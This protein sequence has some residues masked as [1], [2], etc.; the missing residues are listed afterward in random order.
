MDCPQS[1]ECEF[2]WCED[3]KD[4]LCLYCDRPAPRPDPE[5]SQVL[6]D[7]LAENETK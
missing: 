6:T 4:F 3:A 5:L 2:E 7:A 1:E